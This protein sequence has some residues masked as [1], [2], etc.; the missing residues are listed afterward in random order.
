M[1]FYDALA[2]QDST[3]FVQSVSTTIKARFASNPQF[4]TYTLAHWKDQKPAAELISES[5]DSTIA[6]ITYRLK[7]TGKNPIDTTKMTQLYLENGAW[8]FG[9]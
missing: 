3:A 7:T 8:K 4:V 5:H 1:K 6:Y 9:F 2:R